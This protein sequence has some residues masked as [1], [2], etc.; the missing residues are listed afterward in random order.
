ME[1]FGEY[2]VRVCREI[3]ARQNITPAQVERY[4]AGGP[5]RAAWVAYLVSEAFEGRT[6]PKEML[7]RLDGDEAAMVRDTAWK[8]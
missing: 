6:V 2:R 8:R 3:A 4:T 5:W 7:R 1:T